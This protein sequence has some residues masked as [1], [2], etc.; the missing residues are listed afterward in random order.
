MR[1]RQE[2]ACWW[3]ARWSSAWGLSRSLDSNATS[4]CMAEEAARK[5]LDLV[6]CMHATSVHRRASMPC[7]QLHWEGRLRTIQSHPR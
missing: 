7:G 4:A 2:Q 5:V 6:T 1:W 3:E